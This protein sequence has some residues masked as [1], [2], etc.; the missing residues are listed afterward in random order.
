LTSI[1]TQTIRQKG[2]QGLYSGAG[3]LI[4][5]NA[6]KAGVRFMTYD[7]IKALLV[8]ERGKLSPVNGMLGKLRY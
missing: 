2:I 5:G 8:D 3:A 7:S 4:A 1:I 6:L